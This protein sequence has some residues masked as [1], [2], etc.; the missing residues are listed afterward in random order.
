QEPHA[1]A[2]QALSEGKCPD[3]T[4]VDNHTVFKAF[5]ETF[6][7]FRAKDSWLMKF[8]ETIAQLSGAQV[9]L[10]RGDREVF[11]K[12]VKGPAEY[13]IL[14]VRGEGRRLIF[15]PYSTPF[16]FDGV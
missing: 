7:G 14:T 11:R 12:R 1:R 2:A 8:Q 9:Q 16:Q 10:S 3:F 5:F 6:D 15:G 13:L 4:D